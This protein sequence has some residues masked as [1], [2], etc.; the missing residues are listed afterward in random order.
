MIAT[1]VVLH[2]AARPALAASAPPPTFAQVRAVVAARCQTCHNAAYSNKGVVLDTPEL[3]LKH[4]QEID[5]QAVV[6]KAMPLNNATG[7][8]D[9]ERALLGRWYDAGAKP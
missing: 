1:V 4:A 5:Q 3:I 9:D 2:P 6:L 8:T 7:I